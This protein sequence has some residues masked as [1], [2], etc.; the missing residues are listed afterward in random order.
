[1]SSERNNPATEQL[2]EL[3]PISRVMAITGCSRT[4]IYGLIKAGEFPAPLKMWGR[5]IWVLSEVQAWVR[6]QI[7]DRPRMRA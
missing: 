7:R 1:M 3:L 2:E 5:S 4:R 6:E